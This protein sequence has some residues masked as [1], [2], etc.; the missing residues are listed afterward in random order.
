MVETMETKPNPM[1]PP[2]VST[3]LW[4]AVERCRLP[5]GVAHD[6]LPGRLGA[7]WIWPSEAPGDIN[8]LALP[9]A[10]AEATRAYLALVSEMQ[11]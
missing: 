9:S 10:P 8:T 4:A 5:I 11:R 6:G 3:R 7:Y 1:T 2:D